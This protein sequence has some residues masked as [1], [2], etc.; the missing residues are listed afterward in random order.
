MKADPTLPT[1]YAL[2]LLSEKDQ[3][4]SAE[5][6]NHS[7]AARAHADNTQDLATALLLAQAGKTIAPPPGTL[8]EIQAH[9]ATRTR[10]QDLRQRLSRL[11]L[12]GGWAVAASLALTLFLVQ[13]SH[14]NAEISQTKVPD[15][16]HMPREEVANPASPGVPWTAKAPANPVV[17]LSPTHYHGKSELTAESERKNTRKAI[18]V[19]RFR[20]ADQPNATHSI[21]TGKT[22]VDL[23]AHSLQPYLAARQGADKNLGPEIVVERGYGAFTADTLPDGYYYRHRNFPVNDWQSLGLER[24]A[25]GRFY[26]P[27]GGLIWTPDPELPGSYVSTRMD[28]ADALANFQPATEVPV[29]QANSADKQLEQKLIPE[30]PPEV[31]IAPHI[32][33]TNSPLESPQGTEVIAVVDPETNDAQLIVAN[34][35]AIAPAGPDEVPYVWIGNPDVGGDGGMTWEAIGPLKPQIIPQLD[36][37]DHQITANDAGPTAPEAS[38]SENTAPPPLVTQST[39]VIGTTPLN[40]SQ[41]TALDSGGSILGISNEPRTRINRTSDATYNGGRRPSRIVPLSVANDL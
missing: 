17:S 16:S 10:K 38:T 1:L 36:P 13:K 33:S 5:I 27:Q 7:P 8:A 15:K 24:D 30:A 34:P 32:A 18:N 25:H 6:L 28:N 41:T 23:M 29:S 21:L 26:D 19:L 39:P 2:D 14:K 35:G 12:W 40:P 9:I 37:E 20:S 4:L 3:Q 22:L 31:S 11:A